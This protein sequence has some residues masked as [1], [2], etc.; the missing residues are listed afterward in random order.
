MNMDF[1]KIVV[2]KHEIDPQQMFK[3]IVQHW[4]ISWRKAWQPTP[5]FLLGNPMDRG[6]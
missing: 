2:K 3:Y 5:L 1:F 6:A 4:Q